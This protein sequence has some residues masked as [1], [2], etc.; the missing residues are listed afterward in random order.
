MKRNFLIIIIVIIIAAVFAFINYSNK[1]DNY[2]DHRASNDK[3]VYTTSDVSHLK[4]TSNFLP[5]AI[6]HIFFGTVK[7]G[8]AEGFHYANIKNSSS[9]IISGTESAPNAFGVFK[10]KAEIDGKVKSDDNGYSTFFPNSMSPQKV[11]DSI[12]E[13]Y[14]NA[15]NIHGNIYVGKAKNGMKIEM[16][17]TSDGK[18]ISAFPKY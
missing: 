11:I 4:N 13:A 15:Q 7:D 2:H 6:K 14:S 5:S 3:G 18:I 8:K 12:N 16:Y 17:L 10:A 9:C 1:G